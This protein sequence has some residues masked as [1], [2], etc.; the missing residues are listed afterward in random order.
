MGGGTGNMLVIGKRSGPGAQPENANCPLPMKIL[1][2]KV[3]TNRVVKDGVWSYNWPGYPTMYKN[4]G[5]SGPCISPQTTAL[6]FPGTPM[7]YNGECARITGGTTPNIGGI[8]GTTSGGISGDPGK[9]WP[10]NTKVDPACCV[11]YLS[12]SAIDAE[13]TA[14]T[15]FAGGRV[16]YNA[17]AVEAGY[18]DSNCYDPLTMAAIPGCT[19]QIPGNK[20]INDNTHNWGELLQGRNPVMGVPASKAADTGTNFNKSCNRLMDIFQTDNGFDVQ[21][22]HGGLGNMPVLSAGQTN[23]G[24][25]SK[26]H[27]NTA[28]PSN[29]TMFT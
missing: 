18:M 11:N 10:Y 4:Y 17:R 27:L 8:A 6:N 13:G 24:Y 7:A 20:T 16:D 19:Y 14:L 29:I 26:Y 9:Y 5:F 12:I 21:N 23:Y 2:D 25:H 1:W 15:G 22:A 28:Q 3:S